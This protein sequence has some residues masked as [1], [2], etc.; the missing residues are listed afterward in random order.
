[1]SRIVGIIFGVIQLSPFFKNEKETQTLTLTNYNTTCFSHH[2]LVTNT[3][4]DVSVLQEGTNPYLNE[5]PLY[6]DGNYSIGF[7]FI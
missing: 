4:Q 1:V 3:Q 7:A 2:S 5:H 6:N